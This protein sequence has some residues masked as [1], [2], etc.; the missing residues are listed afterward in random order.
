MFLSKNAVTKTVVTSVMF[1]I[2]GALFIGLSVFLSAGGQ[3][4][5]PSLIAG[6]VFCSLAVINA[7][8][9]IYSEGITKVFARGCK[10]VRDELDPEAFIA[11]YNGVSRS[12]N[13]VS[14]PTYDISELL[15]TAYE[16]S[17][18][19]RGKQAQ[20]A[21]M[22]SALKPKYLPRITVL[23]A[24][25]AYDDG[26]ADEGD[27]LLSLAGK[28]YPP[29]VTVSTMIDIAGKTSAA[30][31]RGDL[32]TAESYYNGVLNGSG[33]MKPDNAARL[34]AHWE[35]FRISEQN[36]DTEKALEHLR[37]CAE[38]GGRTAIRSKA[39]SLLK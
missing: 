20:L 3:K 24:C 39:L 19:M 13:A 26:D 34:M 12:A 17:G 7:L 14:R 32:K 1:L 28:K 2:I 16:L 5:A 8:V 11:Y 18:N 25:R 15:L 10:L 6:I 35:L 9:G 37:F 33:I 38:N 22:R 36:G 31:C 29:S 23:E 21:H 27:R 4:Y 30:L